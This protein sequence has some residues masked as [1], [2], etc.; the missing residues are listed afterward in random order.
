MRKL[1]RFVFSRFTVIFLAI[2]GQVALVIA[3]AVYFSEY[4]Q[5]IT[6]ISI[7]LRVLVL[8]TIF[9]R[10][11]SADAKLPWSILVALFPITGFIIYFF[12]SHNYA[13]LAERRMFKKM[14]QLSL[15]EKRPE[16]PPKYLG[17]LNYL[18]AMGAPAF[19]DTDTKYFGC[20]E[21]FF[22]DYVEELKK[23]EK[24]IFLEYFIVEHGKMLDTV[25]DVLRA[26]VKQGVEVRLMYDDFGSLTKVKGSFCRK[27]NKMGIRCVRFAKLKPF[28]S[29]MY[30]NRDH[31]KITVIDGKVGYMSGLNLADE[32]INETHPYGYWKDSAVK[33]Q[34]NAVSSLTT[35]FLQMFGMATKRMEKFDKYLLDTIEHPAEETIPV[36]R[37]KWEGDADSNPEL[38]T[39]EPVMDAPVH[40]TVEGLEPTIQQKGV[41]APF[42]DGPRPIY[43][44]QIGKSVYLHLIDQA[45]HDLY[46]TTPYLIV[47]EAFCES[48]RR[49]AQRGVTVNVLI[50]SI[51]DKKTVY[52]MTKHSCKK[53]MDAGVRVYK[54]TRGFV[55]AKS[56]VA[57]GTAAVVGTINL[58]YRSFIHHYECGVYMYETEAVKQL[59]LDLAETLA[60]SERQ[61][62]PPKLNLLERLICILGN[63]FRPL[64]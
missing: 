11:M 43:Q 29:V 56:I 51:P 50:P 13:S 6:A 59:Y 55:H 17:Q 2:A 15:A 5:V 19:T 64:M 57:D 24:F 20:G 36:I 48:L 22:V 12:F 32:Y 26:K 54:F 40:L 60:Q 14:P 45:V 21:D 7:A 34:G 58:D 23:A 44:E 28:V 30:N 61:H 47:D 38:L 49:A 25:L 52:A 33:M 10:D 18:M 1:F 37:E 39:M 8:L 4:Y 35:M 46:I 31:R 42:G 53:L 16:A 9:N 63:V 62:K 41:V 3:I 27:I